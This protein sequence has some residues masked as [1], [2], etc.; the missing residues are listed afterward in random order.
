MI[1]LCNRYNMPISMRFTKKAV[2][3]RIQIGRESCIFLKIGI[4]LNDHVYRLF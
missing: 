4:H 2:V 3:N 1:I